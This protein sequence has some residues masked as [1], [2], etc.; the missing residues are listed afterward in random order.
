[1]GKRED[2]HGA[3][4]GPLIT[5]DSPLTRPD[6]DTCPKEDHEIRSAD[7]IGLCLSGGGYRAMVFHLG[8]LRRL[9]EVGYLARLADGGRISS[10][11]GG[12][13]TAAV[14]GL[15]WKDLVWDGDVATNLEKILIDPVLT[16]ARE[17][18]DLNAFLHGIIKPGRSRADELAQKLR[19][20]VFGNNTLQDLPSDDEG[21]RFVINA[22]NLQT[23]GLF[24]FSKPY[25]G[26]CSIGFW[27]D[28]ETPIADAVAASAGFPPV[29]S[30][31]ELSAYGTFDPETA[32]ENAGGRLMRVHE[33]GDG[34]IFDNLGLET[35]WNCYRTVLIS[36][37]GA[38]LDV[39]QDPGNSAIVHAVRAALVVDQQVR[40]LRKLQAVGGYCTTDPDNKR[41]GTYWS[42]RSKSHNYRLSDRLNFQHRG[43]QHPRYIPTRLKRLEEVEIEDLL[44]WGYVITDT[45]MRTWVTKNASR[46]YQIDERYSR[47]SGK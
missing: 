1:M 5:N 25:Q 2:D 31:H 27:N 7:K 6:D 26:D 37:G 34:G 39:E 29:L 4:V 30:P 24:R 8:A 36:D 35:V 41:F 38:E 28:P 17:S 47:V 12:S 33:L 40:D 16:V 9:N 42:I 10:V 21:P 11:S 14:L 18:I 19:E 32:S 20:L 23:G 43:E 45:A 3:D 13:I 46:P 44:E 22:T 15:G